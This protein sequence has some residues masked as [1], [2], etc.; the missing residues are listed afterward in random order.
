V[1]PNFVPVALNADRLPDTDDGRFFR[2]L[3]RQWPQGLWVVTPGGQTLGF[4]YYKNTPGL[5]F[6]QNQQ[7]WVD[8]TVAFLEAAVKAA[9]PLS[10][11]PAHA[12]NPFPDRGVGPTA[13]GGARLAVSVVGLRN[14]RQEGPP[15]VDSVLLSKEEWAAFAPPAG[16]KQWQVP[17]AVGRKF[18]PALS[19]ITDSIFVPLPKDVTKA[20]ITGNFVR[21]TGGLWVIRYT[22]TWQSRHLR[23][24]NGNYPITSEE[25]GEG[26]GVYDPAT[27][28][29]RSLLWVL[30][31]TY[32]NG[33]NDHRG[34]PIAAVV[35]WRMKKN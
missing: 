25:S 21:E 5:S 13:D 7:R 3:M 26:V 23:D 1:N 19:P 9:G 6:R 18:A 4:H 10:P 29:M 35:E 32:R 8:T 11:R 15:A 30:K 27:R 24:G 16:A 14:G 12:G 31:G 2:N 17:E 34:T 22:G 33:A 28:S 20:A